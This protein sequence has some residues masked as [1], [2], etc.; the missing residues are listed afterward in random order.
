MLNRI[1]EALA[2]AG[3]PE[4]PESP[5][6]DLADYGLDSLVIVLS[7]AEFEK[8]FQIKIPAKDFRP[9]AFQSLSSLEAFLRERGAN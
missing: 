8:V 7:I 6:A 3:M 5:S 9:E 2:A 4:I 1:R